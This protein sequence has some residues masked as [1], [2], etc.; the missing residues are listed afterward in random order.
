MIGECPAF[1]AFMTFG[2]TFHIFVTPEFRWK[3]TQIEGAVATRAP[4]SRR[5]VTCLLF[6]LLNKTGQR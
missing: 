5:H 4:S 1:F 6:I 2:M 3:W